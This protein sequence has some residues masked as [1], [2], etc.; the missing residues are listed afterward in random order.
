MYRKLVII[1]KI[2]NDQLFSILTGD[3][4]YIIPLITRL[5]T[6]NEKITSHSLFTI[7]I[8]SVD[9]QRNSLLNMLKTPMGISRYRVQ[10]WVFRVQIYSDI[11]RFNNLLH[12]CISTRSNNS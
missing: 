3:V 6:K 5:L 10:I 9:Q 2:T 1:G 4:L 8:R 7:T 12:S 11:T